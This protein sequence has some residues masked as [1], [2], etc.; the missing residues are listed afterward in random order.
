MGFTRRGASAYPGF[1]AIHSLGRFFAGCAAFLRYGETLRPVER[2]V[3]A[4]RDAVRLL[5]QTF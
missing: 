5:I 1:P 3:W 2:G 4:I